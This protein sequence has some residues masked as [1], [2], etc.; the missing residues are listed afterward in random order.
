MEI[1]KHLIQLWSLM[2]GLKGPPSFPLGQEYFTVYVEG[3]TGSGKSTFIEM[4]RSRPDIFVVQE[5]L[6]SWMDVNGTDLFGLMYRDPQRW[7]GAFQLHAS[8]SRLRSVTEKTPWGKRIRILERSIYSQR[9]TF[10]E[11]LIKTEVMAKAETALMDKWFDFM[12]KRFERQMKP[13]LIIYLRGS[14]DVFKERILKR[15]RTEELPY[16]HG[17][18]FNDIH[19]R[20]EDWL[21]HRNSTFPVPAEVLV[22]DANVDIRGFEEQAKYVM[23]HCLPMSPHY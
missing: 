16:L 15:G 13:D 3:P 22:L 17:N 20:H 5:P 19:S 4:F 14:N 1:L 7:S 21:I 2:G 8:L 18:I 6:S 9:Y 12:V 11:H 23:R 10:L